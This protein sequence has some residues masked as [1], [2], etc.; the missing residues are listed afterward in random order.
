MNYTLNIKGLTVNQA[1]KGKRYRTNQYDVFIKNCLL[2]LP[3]TVLI[4]DENNIKLA[5]EFGFSSKL[6]DIDNCLKTFIDCLVKKYK[7]D[8]RY[9]FELHVF[10]SIVKKGDE[11][12]KFRI[13]QTDKNKPTT[14]HKKL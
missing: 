6:S 5:I 14:K 2:L 10:K 11:Y 1:F 13:Y 4:P 12:I 7:V 8:D 3:K 9:I